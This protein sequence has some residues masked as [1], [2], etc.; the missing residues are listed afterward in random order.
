MSAHDSHWDDYG[1]DLVVA[2]TQD[3]V[4]EVILSYLNGNNPL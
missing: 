3:S 4:N 1:Y 2:V